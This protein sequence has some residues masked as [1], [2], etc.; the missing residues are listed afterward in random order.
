MTSAFAAGVSL[1]VDKCHPN[2]L[3]KEVTLHLTL[4]VC[5][6]DCPDCL[7]RNGKRTA[8]RHTLKE[9]GWGDG[10]AGKG[11]L[12]SS[13]D[14]R[15]NLQHM[16]K[17]ITVPGISGLEDQTQED[18]WSLL[19]SPSTESVCSQN[20]EVSTLKLTSGLLYTH[21]HTHPVSDSTVV[22][23]R[24]T[25]KHENEETKLEREK[26]LMQLQTHPSKG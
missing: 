22:N 8:L 15:T 3:I 10:S 17:P 19:G 11:L 25:D 9:Q 7:K 18:P 5:E 1:S 13:E 6:R 26:T 20:Q 23:N 4:Q 2:Y 14:V 24:C 21:T 16:Q 12:H